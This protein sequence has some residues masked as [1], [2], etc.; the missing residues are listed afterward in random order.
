MTS[1][2]A[3]ESRELARPSIAPEHVVAL[4]RISVRYRVPVERHVTLKEFALRWRRN[5]PLEHVALEDVDLRVAR[6]EMLGIIGRNGAGKTSLLNVIARILDPSSG[7]IRVRGRVATL[8]DL[9]GGFH[10]DL[11]GRENIALR[12]ALLG[13]SR[14]EMNARTPEIV[15]FADI[16]NFIDAPMRTWSA[17]MTLRAAFAIA[18]S[19]DADILVIDEVLGVGDA[20]F[21]KKCAARIDDFRARGVTF[22]VVSHDVGR[23]TAMSNRILWLDRGR[24][25]ALGDPAEV[26]SQYLTAQ[27]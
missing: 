21:Q 25:H 13:L 26:V 16:G 1:P 19:V 15:S 14:T 7:R 23:L 4:D 3:A 12:G 2:G 6:G 8:I 17:G 10:P 11:T 20:A 27:E 9:F 22:I 5:R 18:T 24:P